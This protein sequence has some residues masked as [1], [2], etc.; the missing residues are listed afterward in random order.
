[1]QSKFKTK[2]LCILTGSSLGEAM[3][4]L[5]EH[6]IRHL[7]VVDKENNVIAMFSKH[8]AVY[9]EDLLKLPVNIFSSSPVVY[10]DS[11]MPIKKVVFLMLEKKI[12]AVLL[13]D[14][15]SQLLGIITTD[16]LLFHLTQ[17]LPDENVKEI[18]EPILK[19]DTL[20]TIG[21]FFRGL[22]SLGI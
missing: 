2:V 4:M 15:S 9:T 20:V 7:P 19:T 21:E 8:D 1:M 11:N 10:V 16:D 17:F 14:V 5:S 12:S 6:R 13:T 3:E 18:P 22:S